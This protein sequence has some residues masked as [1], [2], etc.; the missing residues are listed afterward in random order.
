MISGFPNRK[1]FHW[2][3][4]RNDYF[5]FYPFEIQKW[6]FWTRIS[7]SVTWLSFRNS[8]YLNFRGGVEW[9]RFGIVLDNLNWGR[10]KLCMRTNLVQCKIN[11]I[12][13]WPLG[14]I[15]CLYCRHRIW[16]HHYVSDFIWSDFIIQP[17]MFHSRAFNTCA[18]HRRQIRNR[19]WNTLLEIVSYTV[20]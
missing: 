10:Q 2:P 1:C 15:P 12:I 19:S 5:S 7:R 14:S 8:D 9:D 20:Y 16:I 6:L 3:Q 13:A 4:L 17:Q 18:S 11:R